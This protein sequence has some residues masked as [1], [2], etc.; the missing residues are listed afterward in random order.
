MIEPMFF[1][2]I[3][4]RNVSPQPLKFS[5][6]VLEIAHAVKSPSVVEAAA[7]IEEAAKVCNCVL[8]IAT[9]I[10]WLNV[11][12]ALPHTRWACGVCMTLAC[13]EIKAALSKLVRWALSLLKNI[14]FIHCGAGLW[15]KWELASH[16]IRAAA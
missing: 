15:V 7:S 1:E 2:C 3:T 8:P 14:V 4:C 9:L 11:T 5:L 6:V 10:C 16:I 13:L 12:L